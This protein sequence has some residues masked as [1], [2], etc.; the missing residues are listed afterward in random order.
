MYSPLMSTKEVALEVINRLPDNVSLQQ[1]AREIE[2]VA[3]VRDGFESYEKE[4]GITLGEAKA[5][6]SA[7]ARAS[8]K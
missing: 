8:T 6:V 3:A 4:G 5:Q 7:W 1:I 2:F